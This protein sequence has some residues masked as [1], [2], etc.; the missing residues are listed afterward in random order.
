MQHREEGE[1]GKWSFGV[2]DLEDGTALSDGG[3][4]VG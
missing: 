3:G 2:E 1:E 4:R